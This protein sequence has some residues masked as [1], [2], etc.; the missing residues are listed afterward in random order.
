MQFHGYEQVG[1][2]RERYAGTWE[3]AR[4]AAHWLRSRFAD[5]Q[6][7]VASQ[8]VPAVREWFAEERLRAG[9]GVVWEASMADGRRVSLS[10]VPAADS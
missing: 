1:D 4:A 9:G 5:Y 8:S 2:T 7:G 3:D 10:V 6:R